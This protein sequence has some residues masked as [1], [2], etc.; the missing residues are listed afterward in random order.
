MQDIDQIAQLSGPDDPR[1]HSI[2]RFILKDV[3]T[4]QLHGAAEKGDEARATLDY[5]LDRSVD[6]NLKNKL[7]QTALHVSVSLARAFLLIE[8]GQVSFSDYLHDYATKYL[9]LG[10]IQPVPC[11]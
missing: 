4:R 11:I 7:Q 10:W 6:I 9:G 1:F 5:L 2:T 8:F 3:R